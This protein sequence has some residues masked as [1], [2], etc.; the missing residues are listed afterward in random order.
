MRFRTVQVSACSCICVALAWTQGT[1]RKSGS[2]RKENQAESYKIYSSLIPL[3]ETASANFPH[4]LWL[5]QNKTITVVPADKPCAPGPP[6]SPMDPFGGNPHFAVHPPAQWQPDFEEILHD[7][8]AHCHVRLDLDP[9]PYLWKVPGPVRLLT[10]VEQKEF[11]STRLG[12][13]SE[14]TGKYEGA[15]ALYGLQG[16]FQ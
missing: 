12:K 13:S 10:P 6:S 14:F 3:G 5:V 11:E 16:L 2:P 4:S 9:N 1:V 15:P 7:F 8:D